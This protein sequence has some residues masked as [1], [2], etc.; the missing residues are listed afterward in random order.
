MARRLG[1]AIT[2]KADSTR[3]IYAAEHI[4]V[5]AYTEEDF[6]CL[7][8]NGEIFGFRCGGIETTLAF[9]GSREYLLAIT[10]QKLKPNSLGER[11][12]ILHSL[13]VEMAD[14][15]ECAFL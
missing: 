5:K 8:G 14:C 12:P 7:D 3:S 6:I 1:S 11:V 13:L 4:R 2:S 9:P 15:S 10:P